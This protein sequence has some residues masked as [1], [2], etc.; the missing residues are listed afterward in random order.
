M[1]WVDTANNSCY[2]DLNPK[3]LYECTVI[4][5]T[6]VLL[7]SVK[8]LSI[9]KFLCGEWINNSY[10]NKVWLPAEFECLH[11]NAYDWN[12]AWFITSIQILQTDGVISCIFYN[13]QPWFCYIYL[14]Y[15]CCSND[16]SEENLLRLASCTFGVYDWKWGKEIW[17]G[18]CKAFLY[19]FLNI[20]Q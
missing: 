17:M 12:V 8:V 1:W 13:F 5:N 2:V 6:F 7:W 20:T 15:G 19:T 3:A 18:R 9:H 4:E 11:F 14:L 16:H 10:N